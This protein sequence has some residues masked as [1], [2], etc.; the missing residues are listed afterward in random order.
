MLKKTTL[1]TLLFSFVFSIANASAPATSEDHSEKE[2]SGSYNPVPMIMHHIADA[3]EIHFWGK[4]ENSVSI[5]L[6][7]ILW[8]DNGLV[9]FMNSEFHH[10]DDGGTIVERE[11]V[12]FT[13]SHGKIYYAN[14]T[15][16]SHGSYITH[17]EEGHSKNAK[18]LDF[19]ITKSVVGI[20]LT[21]IILL[22]VFTS[23]ARSYK[24]N[25]GVPRKLTGW[26]EPLVVFVRDDIAKA[27][28]GE[29]KYK[30]YVPFLLSIFFFILVLNILGLT[31]LGFNVTGNIAVTLVLAV[32]SL[33]VTLIS[34]NKNYW[35][36]IFN[37][38]V[39]VLLKPL[40]IPIEI[41]GIFTKPFALMI[42]LFANITA[43]HIVILSLISLIFIAEAGSGA[44]TAWGISPAA[45]A[46]TLFI[47]VLEVLV[48][49]LQAYIFTLLTGLFIGMSVEEH[50]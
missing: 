13:K 22:L 44:G 21:M 26:M 20:F 28:I 14:E 32:I 5:P 8:T 23:V 42:R 49:F 1:L 30:K 50:H 46:L 37:P 11:G 2:N 25:G 35:G 41:V 27:N 19:S 15:A 34:A 43:G 17:D 9:A 36:H 12:K 3:H 33:I 6:P 48:A 39:P 40:M 24:K 29:A 45:F 4:G 10:N 38:P 18:P 16:D 47:F 7:I 31:P